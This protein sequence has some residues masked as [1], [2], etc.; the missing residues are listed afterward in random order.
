MLPQKS[1]VCL[2]LRFC[3]ARTCCYRPPSAAECGKID[4]IVL[5]HFA[6]VRL[7]DQAPAGWFGA[8]GKWALRL[9]CNDYCMPV[10]AAAGAAAILESLKERQCQVRRGGR[11][12]GDGPGGGSQIVPTRL[13]LLLECPSASFPY[14]LFSVTPFDPINLAGAAG[15]GGRSS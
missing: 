13:G 5:T 12:F 7:A 15:R 4:A 1:T 3:A 2:A 14:Q 8:L 10:A 11:K 9:D 6:A